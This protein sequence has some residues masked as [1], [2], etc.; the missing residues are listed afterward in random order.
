MELYREFLVMMQNEMKEKKNLMK[1]FQTQPPDFSSSAMSNK[2]SQIWKNYTS[3]AVKN[4]VDLELKI[5][6]TDRQQSVAQ[7]GHS[8]AI[9]TV[10]SP[11]TAGYQS[12]YLQTKSQ[13]TS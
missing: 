12:Q 11:R 3:G 2:G 6:E 9:Q 10:A 7:M 1:T 8:S 5:T 13:L 4:I